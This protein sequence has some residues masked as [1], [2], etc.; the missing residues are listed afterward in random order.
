MPA[1][2]K[3]HAPDEFD[4]VDSENVDPLM[5]T[6]PSKK[7]RSV[8][9]NVAMTSKAPLFALSSL[10]MPAQYVERAA[11][12][13]QKR[14]AEEP[15]STPDNAVQTSKR[16]QPSSAPVPAGRSPKSKKTGILSRRRM[17]ASPFTRVNPPAFSAG[18]SSSGMPF[19]IDAALAGT[20]PT[21]KSKS[22]SKSSHR[23]SW[24][25]EIHEDTKDVED[26]IL[27][28]HSACTLDISGDE[29]RAAA[30]ED[31]DNKENIPPADGVATLRTFSQVMSTRRDMMADEPRSPLGNLDAKDFYADGCDASSVTIIGVED[32]ADDVEKCNA[33]ST[34][35]DLCSPARSRANAITDANDGWKDII[36]QVLPK[37]PL[38]AG[39]DSATLA[40]LTTKA[41]PCDI[42]IWESESAKGDDETHG[43]ELETGGI[44][45][46]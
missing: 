44:G 37:S 14:K 39:S 8:D 16:V 33:T 7:S 23:K 1:P 28:E 26:T 9:F 2:L 35:S 27:M 32:V 17:T 15:A 13:G 3:R 25:F 6:T 10:K 46:Q 21:Y 22:K 42:Q 18:E 43:D 4:D 20:V 30:K 31:K 45:V 11:V 19:S 36:A 24:Q 40:D 34:T 29:T 5:F 41:E 38:T 12:T